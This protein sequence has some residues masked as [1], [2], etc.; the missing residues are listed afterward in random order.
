MS[1]QTIPYSSTR[2][3]ATPGLV[4]DIAPKRIHSVIVESAIAAG[5]LVVQ[6]ST[7]KIE[8]APPSAPSAAATAIVSTPVATALTAQTVSGASLDGAVGQGL[9]SPPKNVTL[10]LSN[11]ADFDATT[12]VVTGEDEEGQV[13]EED[14]AIPNGGNATVTGAKIFAKITSIYIPAQSGTGGTLTVGTGVKLGAIDSIVHGVSVYDASREPGTYA[15][16]SL[17]PVLREGV[18]W[19]YAETAV[20]PS[21]PVY[22]RFVAAGAETLGRFRSTVDS[23]DLGRL[24]AARWLDTTSAEGYARLAINLP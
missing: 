7:T 11:H 5:L 10:T 18:V 3:Q 1:V 14:F 23:T 16:D 15:V 8:G 2:D 24:R 20:N 22:A 13:I 17:M 21:L 4:A 12:A 19:V 9:I 6:G